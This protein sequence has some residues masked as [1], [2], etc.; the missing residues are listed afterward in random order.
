MAFFEEFL[1]ESFI[2]DI[3]NFLVA[4]EINNSYALRIDGKYFT[5]ET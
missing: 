5:K 2:S 4:T 3:L 1:F